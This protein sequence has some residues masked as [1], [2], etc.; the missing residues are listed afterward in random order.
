M[1][2]K[3]NRTQACVCLIPT[4]QNRRVEKPLPGA[5][6]TPYIGHCASLL[7]GYLAWSQMDHQQPVKGRA[8]ERPQPAPAL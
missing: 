1:G 2:R 4:P 8:Y 3:R 5:D 6:A 7:C